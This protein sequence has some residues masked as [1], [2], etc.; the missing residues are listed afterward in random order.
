[1][2]GEYFNKL[3]QINYNGVAVRDVTRRVNFLNQA[4]QNPYIYL[5]YTIQE[6]DRA[7][8][9]AYHYYGNVNY[10][11]LVYLAN[12]IVDP[13]NEWPMDEETFHNYLMDKYKEQSGNLKGW[14]V[15]A[16]T[17]DTTNTDNIVYYYKEV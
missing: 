9:I 2:S 3:P 7:E 8:D 5:P 12:N 4:S 15:V 17:Q 10:A 13:Y 11:W 6:G 14:D 1:M 16:W